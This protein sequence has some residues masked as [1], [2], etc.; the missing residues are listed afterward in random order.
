MTFLTDHKGKTKL[1]FQ[2]SEPV[3][4]R[5]LGKKK[6][7]RCTGDALG[8]YDGEKGFDFSKI[9]RNSSFSLVLSIRIE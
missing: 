2:R 3:A 5:R 8:I 7:I 1:V 9:H 4:D 6:K